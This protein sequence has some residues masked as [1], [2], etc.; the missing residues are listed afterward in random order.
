MST[1]A[2]QCLSGRQ[3]LKA[4]PH[5]RVESYGHVEHEAA[6]VATGQESPQ[7]PP[8]ISELKSQYSAYSLSSFLKKRR[9]RSVVGF[10]LLH[11]TNTRI[12]AQVLCSWTKLPFRPTWPSEGPD[13]RSRSL[14]PVSRHACGYQLPYQVM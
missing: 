12:K 14:P 8:L 2:H 11:V 5:T 4:L 1:S 13:S 9:F 10:G 6:E 3:R 7:T